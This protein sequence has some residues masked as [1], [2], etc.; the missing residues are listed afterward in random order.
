[1]LKVV[2]WH[3]MC[4]Y[5]VGLRLPQVQLTHLLTDIRGHAHDGR[6][7]FGHHAFRFLDMI[8]ASFAAPFLMGDSTDRIDLWRDTPRLALLG[9][10][11]DRKLSDPRPLPLLADA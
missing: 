11:H 6:L 4:M 2:R 3:Q 7:P 8:Q 5:G 9:I 1:M 10:H